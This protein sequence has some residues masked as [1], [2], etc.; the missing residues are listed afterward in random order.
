MPSSA[1]PGKPSARDAGK[2]VDEYVGGLSGWQRDAA[3]ALRRIAREAAPGARE[4]IKWGQPVYEQNG[5][6]AWMKAHKTSVNFGF[7]RGAEL[8]DPAGLLEGEGDRMRHVKVREGA[9][10]PAEELRRMIG[11]AVRL[12][13]EKGDPTRRKR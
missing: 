11:E 13:E 4:S 8:A 2:S 1:D 3:A 5:P 6:V 10:V 12:N 7:W 9:M